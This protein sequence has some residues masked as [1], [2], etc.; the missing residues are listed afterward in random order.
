MKAVQMTLEEDL[1][2]AVD[3]LVRRLKTT[4]SAFARD[5]L[6]E[7]LAK[8]RVKEL[9]QKHRLGY[10]RHPVKSGEFDLWATEQRWGD[11]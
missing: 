11:E 2:A 9:E 7:A 4:R 3:R 8:H 6:R 5:A 10:Q 1:V